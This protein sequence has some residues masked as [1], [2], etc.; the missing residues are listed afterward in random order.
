MKTATMGLVQKT[1]R[2]WKAGR[3]LCSTYQLGGRPWK[4]TEGWL[5]WEH[6][7]KESTNRLD[8]DATLAN[9]GLVYSALLQVSLKY[10]RMRFQPCQ[11]C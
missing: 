9:S 3:R 10:L 8:V 11:C 1:A 6:C 7:R 2:N 5:S 4:E